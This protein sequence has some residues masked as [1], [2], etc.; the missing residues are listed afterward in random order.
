MKTNDKKAENTTMLTYSD[1]KPFLK[2]SEQRQVYTVGDR[3]VERG[4]SPDYIFL[5]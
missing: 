5:L 3:V 2:G 1:I 4:D